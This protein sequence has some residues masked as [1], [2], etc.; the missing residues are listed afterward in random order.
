[1]SVFVC[2]SLFR[3]WS[4]LYRSPSSTSASIQ[5]ASPPNAVPVN[6][7]QS[8]KLPVSTVELASPDQIEEPTISPSYS[9][10]QIPPLEPSQQN[11]PR[12]FSDPPAIDTGKQCL[13][14]PG[15]LVPFLCMWW[16]H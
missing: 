15:Q 12:E 16:K 6:P 14:I 7:P 1:M 3:T 5:A 11:Y 2:G 10:E 13:L 8:S 4:G 9:N